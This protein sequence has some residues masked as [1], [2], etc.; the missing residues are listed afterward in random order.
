M[1]TTSEERVFTLWLREKH[2]AILDGF[3]NGPEWFSQIDPAFRAAGLV[4]VIVDLIY[5]LERFPNEALQ[6]LKRERSDWPVIV[7]TKSFPSHPS[8][9][10]H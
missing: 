6:E 8:L 7:P 5:L 10:M 1:T 2:Q 4:R 9:Q 3:L